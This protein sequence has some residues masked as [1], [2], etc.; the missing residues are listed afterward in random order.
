MAVKNSHYNFPP[1][2]PGYRKHKSYAY[3]FDTADRSI[4]FKGDTGPNEAISSLA[5]GAEM[6][7]SEVTSIEEWKGQKIRIGSLTGDDAGAAGRLATSHDGRTPHNRGS[8]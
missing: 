4:V 5:K 3:R 7:V 8:R 6:L 1:Q 2:S